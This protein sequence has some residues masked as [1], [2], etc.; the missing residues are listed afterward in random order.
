MFG[1]NSKHFNPANF[2]DVTS[3]DV[4]RAKTNL[5]KCYKRDDGVWIEW[6]ES[7]VWTPSRRRAEEILNNIRLEHSDSFGWFEAHTEIQERD[8]KHGK[9][10]RAVR[11]HYKL[12]Y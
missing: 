5:D 4:Q 8:G 11:C 12:P 2:R 9:E 6:F 1:F 10:Y 7:F 3:A